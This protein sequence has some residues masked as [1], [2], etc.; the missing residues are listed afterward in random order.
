MATKKGSKKKPSPA[1]R[2]RT[3]GASRSKT[4]PIKRRTSSGASKPARDPNA[5]LIRAVQAGDAKATT[6]ALAA[7]A[8]PHA[9]DPSGALIARHAVDRH[10]RTV[11]NALLKAGLDVNR[12][13]DDD[14]WSFLMYAHD[15]K[16]ARAL[17][18]HGADVNY[19]SAQGKGETVLTM[20][21]GI[22][23]KLVGVYLEAG[24]DPNL[25]RRDGWT[26]LHIAGWERNAKVIA[27]L[28]AAGARD[29]PR[30]EDGHRAID[31]AIQYGNDEIIALLKR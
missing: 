4:K 7:G 17:I 3:T 26:P 10:Y 18:D 30:P 27:A 22:H 13:L 5:S 29:V 9:L 12:P 14:E 25:A 8:D 28:L 20:A 15:E 11:V 6:A 16:I 19:R 1:A 31:D 21:C 24:A 2:T 23:P